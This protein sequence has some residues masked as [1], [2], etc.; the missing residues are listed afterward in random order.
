V[1]GVDDS[2]IPLTCTGLP[3]TQ[4]KLILS[5]SRLTN[6]ELEDIWQRT[7]T[8]D[9]PGLPDGHWTLLEIYVTLHF[10]Q[11][12]EG[13]S[14]TQMAVQFAG[15]APS[16]ATYVIRRKSFFAQAGVALRP[17]TDHDP[18]PIPSSPAPTALL[19][20]SVSNATLA[21]GMTGPRFNQATSNRDN[22]SLSQPGLEALE[23]FHA[24]TFRHLGG[25]EILGHVSSVRTDTTLG[26]Q[27]LA[28]L[29]QSRCPEVHIGP[30]IERSRP[31]AIESSVV[32]ISVAH[33]VLVRIR[34]QDPKFRDQPK[35]LDKIFKSK[36]AKQNAADSRTWTFESHELSLALREAVGES[37]NVGVAKELI[38]M[39]ADVNEFKSKVKRS[40][41]DSIPINYSQIA[42]NRNDTDMVSLLATSGIAP[43]SLVE[44]L[45]QSV[46]QNL[47]NVV[48][49]LLQHGVDPNAR[50]GSIFTSVITSQNPN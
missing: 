32:D 33:D 3:D 20:H 49:T 22:A 2:I 42:A 35:I 30:K 48:M 43:N 38:S 39:G 40:R 8:I 29:I 44:A 16:E 46:E 9:A 1:V 26:A 47:P 34:R 15:S 4:A 6:E 45:E 17:A 12:A 27:R 41:V 50:S 36:K 25:N 14:A 28:R 23:P 31:S 10:I 18:M 11:M 5:A 19:R 37:G 7:E 24:N 21:T 13:L